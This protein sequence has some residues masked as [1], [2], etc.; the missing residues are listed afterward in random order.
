MGIKK[1]I[2]FLRNLFIKKTNRS[3][4]RLKRARVL[5]NNFSDFYMSYI[6]TTHIGYSF[7]VENQ[8]IW[9]FQILF[10]IMI[11]SI[12]RFRVYRMWMLPYKPKVQTETTNGYGVGKF[13]D[14]RPGRCR[15]PPCHRQPACFWVKRLRVLLAVVKRE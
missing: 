9:F 4:F 13:V 1:N 5:L 6:Y 3:V 15:R 8:S 14:L 2:V 11:Y 10:Y 12:H 7:W